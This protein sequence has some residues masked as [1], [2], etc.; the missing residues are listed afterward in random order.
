MVAGLAGFGTC[1]LVFKDSRGSCRCGE[2]LW[3]WTEFV[4]GMELYR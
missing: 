4:I 2:R 1:A 3:I